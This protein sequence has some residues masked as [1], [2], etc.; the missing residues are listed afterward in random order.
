[1]MQSLTY[2]PQLTD[3][4]RQV[5]QGTIETFADL[6]RKVERSV[7]VGSTP[8]NPAKLND[9]VSARLDEVHAVLLAVQHFLRTQS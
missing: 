8:P 7:A 3:Q 4:Q 1:M 2:P 5:L 6:E 9:I